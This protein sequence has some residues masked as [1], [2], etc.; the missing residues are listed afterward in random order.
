MALV[1]S[2][3]EAQLVAIFNDTTGKTAAVKANEMASAIDTY[4]KTATV[5]VNVA[6]TGTAAAQTGT[7]TGTLS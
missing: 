5:S 3:L 7:G 4:I 2:T 1:V 6:T